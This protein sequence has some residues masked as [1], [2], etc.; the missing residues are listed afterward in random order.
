MPSVLAFEIKK[1]DF[2]FFSKQ[3]DK[4]EHK[5]VESEFERDIFCEAENKN[6]DVKYIDFMKFSN[7]FHLK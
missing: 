3:F 4:E 7:F 1:T 6:N 2:E 5:L